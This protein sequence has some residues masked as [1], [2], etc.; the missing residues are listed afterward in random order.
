M[1]IENKIKSKLKAGGHVFGTWSMLA[2]PSVM[3]VIGQS[4]LDFVIIDMEHGPMSFETVEQ[5]IY[6]TE[7]AGATPIVRFGEGHEP[8]I[9]RTLD[10][11]TQAV[12]VSHV[13][14][15]EEASRI[16][17]ACRYYP[18]GERGLSPFI[19]NHGYTDT[20]LADKLLRANE[21]MLVGVLVEGEI[22]LN[23]LE[24]I[25]ATPGLDIIYLGIYDISQSLGIPGEL[26]HPKVISMLRECARI[27]E[28]QGVAAG[29][30]ARDRDYLKLLFESGFRFLS[31]RV[32]SAILREG[33]E[34]ARGWYNE[35]TS[36][37]S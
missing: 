16:V 37:R 30:V 13:S 34:S 22:G 33:F 35:I 20:D 11:G 7:S 10:I 9:M 18:D 27:S 8:T 14:T 24:S 15:P 3:N 5:Q 17:R 21:Q 19:R 26:N 31:Y 29:S 25:A 36:G 1:T 12:L 32:D 6:A 28:A 4:G 23:N 2:S